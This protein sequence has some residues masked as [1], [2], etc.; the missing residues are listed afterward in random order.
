[1][2]YNYK[3]FLLRIV[4]ETII[5]YKLLLNTFC[6]FFMIFHWSPSDS[7]T[8]QVSR[9]LLSILSNAVVWMVS[10]STPIPNLFTKPLGTISSTLIA[11]DII[12]TFLLHSFQ[13]LWQ[14]P[15]TCPFIIIII[16]FTIS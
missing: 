15:S 11:I 3:L 9:T 12:V 14:G 5:V 13:V 1:M 2:L 7:R 16:V 10:I 6:K 4:L 8:P